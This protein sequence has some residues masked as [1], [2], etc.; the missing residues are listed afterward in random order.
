M[1]ATVPRE[2][3]VAGCAA[4]GIGG[5]VPFE[6]F[7]PAPGGA[8][9]DRH[10]QPEAETTRERNRGAEVEQREILQQRPDHRAVRVLGDEGRSGVVKTARASGSRGGH[11]ARRP[12]RPSGRRRRA[13]ARDQ[14]RRTPPPPAHAADNAR[15]TPSAEAGEVPALAP[16][17]CQ[18]ERCECECLRTSCRR[19]ARP[20]SRHRSGRG[21]TRDPVAR[22]AGGRRAGRGRRP[23]DRAGPSPLRRPGRCRSCP[24]GRRGRR[25]RPCR[26]LLGSVRVRGSP[27]ATK[28]PLASAV[29][30]TPCVR[31]ASVPSCIAVVVRVRIERIEGAVAIRVLE[32]VFRVLDAVVVRVV[33]TPG[34]CRRRPRRRPSMPVVVGVPGA[35]AERV[36]V[37]GR[38]RGG[39]LGVDPRLGLDAERVPDVRRLRPS[40]ARRSESRA[41]SS[42]PASATSRRVDGQRP[43][44]PASVG[45]RAAVRDV[46]HRAVSSRSS[47]A[48]LGDVSPSSWRPLR[49]ASSAPS[50]RP[51][52]SVSARNGLVVVVGSA[53]ATNTPA[54]RSVSG[55]GSVTPSSSPVGEAVV[56]TVRIGRVHVS[57]AVGV[58]ESVDLRPVGAR[59]RRR[60]PRPSPAARK[61]ARP[62]TSGRLASGSALEVVARDSPVRSHR[63]SLA[64]R[65]S[66][67]PSVSARR[68]S[69][70]AASTRPLRLRSSSPSSRPSP[71]LSGCRGF[72]PAVDLE[73]VA[74]AVVVGVVVEGGRAERGLLRGGQSVGVEVTG[75]V[76]GRVARVRPRGELPRRRPTPPPSV[77][78][79]RGIG[80]RRIHPPVVIRVFEHHRRGRR[81]RCRRAGARCRPCGPRGRRRVRRG[82]CRRCAGWCEVRFSSAVVRPSPSGSPSG[83]SSGIAGVRAR[84]DLG[85][86]RRCHPPSVSA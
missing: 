81:H 32:A 14:K 77:S 83:S 13:T 17:E 68:G 78:T 60:C 8:D 64:R 28:R 30:R 25:R 1:S 21:A 11:P 45:R 61:P 29:P 7:A 4:A 41:T 82:R 86:R 33:V 55:V 65:P 16:P 85:R 10:R 76:V 66:P 69:L 57:V 44:W 3:D 42:G 75:R 37:G 15:V 52:P 26:P 35:S 63:R 73:A 74:E 46:L 50:A 36:L 5:R 71:S 84:A 58:L 54:S 12:R 18:G 59:R 34:S 72:G 62:G 19:L 22:P 70:S 51:P 48:R 56:V 49:F 43:S 9:G 23:T 6:E 38:R 67:P 24:P 20:G 27:S 40:Q 2:T 47:A 31:P 80:F 53:S 39:E 79:R